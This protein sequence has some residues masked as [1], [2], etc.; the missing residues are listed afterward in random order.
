[1]T[2]AGL[3]FVAKSKRAHHSLSVRLGLSRPLSAGCAPPA[4]LSALL[5]V[6]R[7]AAL[8][9]A[10][11]LHVL[12]RDLERDRRA[13]L[14]QPLGARRLARP[15]RGCVGALRF[16]SR[17]RSGRPHADEVARLSLPTHGLIGAD[18]RPDWSP[19]VNKRLV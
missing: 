17:Q 15:E 19:H 1:M 11:P 18:I 9:G 12:D 14:D 7:G 10:R 5:L 13:A 16:D 8:Q 4:V 6:P 2:G 3:G